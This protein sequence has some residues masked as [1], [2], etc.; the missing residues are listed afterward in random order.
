MKRILSTAYW[1]NLHYFY[2][3]LHSEYIC[4]EQFEHYQKQSYRN[5]TQILSANGRLNLSIPVKKQAAKELTRHVEISYAEP[6]QNKHWRAITSAYKNS[7]YFEYFEDEIKIFYTQKY[8][9]LID[10]NLLQLKCVLNILKLEKIISLSTAF[11]KKPLDYLDLREN[12]HP[13]IDFKTDFISLKTLKQ[14]YYQTFE[15]KFAFEPNLSVLD[16]LFNEGLGAADYLL[17]FNS[18]PAQTS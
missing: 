6:W 4:I 2:Y 12:I 1:P 15:T 13:K 16:L 5:R 3:V 14:P 9:H 18:D 10:F 8:Q 7:P 17:R 11:E